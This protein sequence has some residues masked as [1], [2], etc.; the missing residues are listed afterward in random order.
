[1]SAAGCEPND[2]TEA[3]VDDYIARGAQEWSWPK[4]PPLP[5]P[6]DRTA[7]TALVLVGLLDFFIYQG[8]AGLGY[9]LL[10]MLVG[11]LIFA[12]GDGG[13]RA[14][15]LWP[16]GLIALLALK[17]LWAS[18]SLSLVVGLILLFY[19]A[20]RRVGLTGCLL[21]LGSSFF[22]SL[23]HSPWGG[24]ALG[25]AINRIPLCRWL[26]RVDLWTWGAPLGV[27]GVFLAI[28][29][30]GNPQVAAWLS[31]AGDWLYNWF[32]DCSNWLPGADRV[33]FWVL[34]GL[35]AALW[36]LPVAIPLDRLKVWLGGTESLAESLP[37][38][39]ASPRFY[40][41]AR[42][43]L[44]GV[45]LLFAAYNRID[46]TDLWIRGDLPAGVDYS[47]YA[48]DG[49]TWLTVALAVTSLVLGIVFAG[50]L[51]HH[52]RVK[53]LRGLA[54]VWLLQNLLLVSFAYQRLGLYV[55]FNGL[56]R[57][58]QV[59]FCGITLVV[60][61]LLLVGY[62]IQAHR[63][64]LWLVRRQL[65]ALFLALLALHFCPLDYLAHSF[66]ARQI[67]AG[68]IGPAYQLISQ[69]WSAEGLPPLLALLDASDPVIRQGVAA[70]LQRDLDLLEAEATAHPRWTYGELSRL[71][72]RRC[73]AAHAIR[74]QGDY[75]F[76]RI[77]ALEE[78][79][80]GYKWPGRPNRQ[81]QP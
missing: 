16:A 56:T 48:I 10:F 3:K 69:P 43:T 23:A 61:G 50:E 49:A 1:M 52:P 47:A 58:R 17:T 72:A 37:A 29:S 51:N 21:E 7:L 62:K 38:E 44:V 11:G 8:S 36:L 65:A 46:L 59:G 18:D 35:L 80:R 42:N 32:I 73:L 60:V 63:S 12:A 4:L 76:A 26:N 45:N 25:Q 9:A 67:L 28:F 33:A 55:S 78:Y 71:W 68:R 75:D 40:L 2:S 13:G 30:L 6:S 27:V 31:Q 66:N 34:A 53:V 22:G 77:A 20:A 24:V 54:G 41:M 19:L 64:F 5:V 74:P 15:C 57:W 39:P 81:E 14:A 79:T 70:L